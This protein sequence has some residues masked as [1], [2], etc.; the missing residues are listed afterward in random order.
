MVMDIPDIPDNRSVRGGSSLSFSPTIVLDETI[1]TKSEYNHQ[2]ETP[3]NEPQ[4]QFV[5]EDHK[6]SDGLD[7]MRWVQQPN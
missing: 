6:P 4:E 5:P 7:K 3:P 1:D 2:L